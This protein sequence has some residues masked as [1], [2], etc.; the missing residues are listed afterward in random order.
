MELYDILGVARDATTA[1]IKKAYRKLALSFHP[2]KVAKDEKE[3][4]ER[5]FQLFPKHTLFFQSQ[6]SERNTMR[7][8]W[9]V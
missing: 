1:E 7:M 2:D 9:K 5:K 3:D 4:S 6:L 8:V